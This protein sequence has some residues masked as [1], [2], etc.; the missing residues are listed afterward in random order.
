LERG[1]S[2]P[3]IQIQ[4]DIDPDILGDAVNDRATVIPN[5]FLKH[6]LRS[7]ILLAACNEVETAKEEQS[8]GLF[9]VALL[10]TLKAVG[11]HELTYRDV[12]Q[13]IHTLPGYIEC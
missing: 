8:R 11:A 7:H 5:G 2:R 1:I 13:R 6:G 12:M 4:S 9:T 10:E 3:D